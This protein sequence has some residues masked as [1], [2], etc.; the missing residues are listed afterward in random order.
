MSS[1]A[2][3]LRRERRTVA[4]M[5][6]IYCADR[7]AGRTDGLCPSCREFLDYAQR[8]LDKCPYGDEKPTCANCPVHCYKPARRELARTIMRHAG[9][10]MLLRHPLLAIAHHLDG[11]RQVRHPRELTREQRRRRSYRPTDV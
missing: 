1:K 9:P 10:R 4:A 11:L 5:I 3:H 6:G 7:H 2:P 8:R